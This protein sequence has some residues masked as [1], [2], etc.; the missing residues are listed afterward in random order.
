MLQKGP[1][2]CELVPVVDPRTSR[3]PLR[4]ADLAGLVLVA[5]LLRG[6]LAWG[7]PLG[8]GSADPNCAPDE[9]EHVLMVK[10]L[11]RGRAPTWP[12]TP[13]IYGAFLP[14]VYLPHAA[15]L[16]LGDRWAGSPFLYRVF[17]RWPVVVG[18]PIARL[19]SILMGV[20]TVLAIAAIAGIWTSSR[21]SALLAGLVAAVFPQ[22]VFLNAYVNADSFTVAAGALL[23]LALSAWSIAGEGDRG[24][25]AIGLTAALVVGGKPS[26]YFILVPTAVWLGWAWAKGRL[27]HRA[28]L[29]GAA[30]A[31][32]LVAPLLAWNLVRNDGDLL[33]VGKF[34]TWLAQWNRPDARAIPG[35]IALA[36]T[37]LLESSFARFR[38]MDLR[39]PAPFYGS[40]YLLLTIGLAVAGRRTLRSSCSRVHRAA[41]WLVGSVAVNLALVVYDTWFVEFQAQ[42]R[43]ILLSVLLLTV[44]AVLAPAHRAWSSIYVGF[45]LVAS[46][47]SAIVVV[48][49]P[50]LP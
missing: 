50:C 17:P 16:A 7:I 25:V 42:G 33:G 13:T 30:V 36:S 19:G 40:A 45:L 5:I 15:A 24:I 20:V 3:L 4:W 44:V 38:N 39:L 10:E 28:A 48:G 37:T 29:R 14:T 41:A 22:L 12:D 34:H 31:V 21:R 35:A 6:I 11:A 23:V 47:A 18:Y 49:N 2:A 46:V 27:R 8:S 32:A 26:G 9:F 43:W 1:E